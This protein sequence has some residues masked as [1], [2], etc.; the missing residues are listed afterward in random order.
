[1]DGIIIIGINKKKIEDTKSR[2][3]AIFSINDLGS[4]KYFLGI[5]VARTNEGLVLSQRKYTI[6]VLEDSGFLGF[7]LSWFLMEQNL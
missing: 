3:D 6:D 2:L 5:E 4:L 7:R 1:M